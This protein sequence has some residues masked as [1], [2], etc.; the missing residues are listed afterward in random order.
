MKLAFNLL[1]GL[2][3]EEEVPVFK[4]LWQGAAFSNVIAFGWRVLWGRI[5]N[6]QNLDKRRILSAD[7]S[8]ACVFCLDN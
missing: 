5:Q 1:Q 3:M 4:L 6:K 2:D 7:V 8:L